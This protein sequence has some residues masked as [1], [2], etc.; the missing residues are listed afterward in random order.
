MKHEEILRGLV[1]DTESNSNVL[2]F[3]LFGS[4]AAGTHHE[5]SDIDVITILRTNKPASGINNTLVDGI[6]VGAFFLTYDV[7][8]HSVETVPYL[9][10]PFGEAKL[11]FDRDGKNKYLL[12]RIGKYYSD[13]P[14][15]VSEWNNYYE[16]LKEE[17]AQ[18]GYEKTTIADVWNEL[19][20]RYSGGKI[21]RRFF[22]SFYMTNPL[23]FSLLKKLLYL[24]AVRLDKPINKLRTWHRMH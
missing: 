21:K 24:G 18:F 11:L 19:E 16:Q 12:E 17:K 3:L 7:L 14:E 2:G 5:V 6:K 1:S 8:V 4:V 15:I 22:N 20:K 10:H 13:H 9:L 23:V